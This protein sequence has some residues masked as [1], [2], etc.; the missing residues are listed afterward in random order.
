MPT[1]LL[2]HSPGKGVT[3]EIMEHLSET[4]EVLVLSYQTGH[5]YKMPFDPPAWKAAGWIKEKIE[6][7]CHLEDFDNRLVG[8]TVGSPKE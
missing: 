4:I 1:R 2:L 8:Y 3:L 6:D 5:I 7:D